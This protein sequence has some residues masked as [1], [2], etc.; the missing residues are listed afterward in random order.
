MPFFVPLSVGIL[1][2]Y[3]GWAGI[4]GY[5]IILVHFVLIA[6]IS[7][8]TVKFRKE[9]VKFSDSRMKM[10]SNLIEGIKVVKLYGWEK[11]MLE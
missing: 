4:V 8:A 7:R 2:Y 3:L 1:Y 9:T 6:L 5:C 10:I 11:P